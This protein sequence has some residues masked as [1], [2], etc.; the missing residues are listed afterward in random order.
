M[1]NYYKNSDKERFER[2]RNEKLSIH[3][4]QG[5]QIYI[6]YF[7]GTTLWFFILIPV[8]QF[9]HHLSN[10]LHWNNFF[11]SL[12]LTYST[13]VFTFIISLVIT[14]IYLYKYDEND[15]EIKV[16][17]F[18][19]LI[20][21]ITISVLVI[22]ICPFVV[23]IILISNDYNLFP[24]EMELC[25]MQKIFHIFSLLLYNILLLLFLNIFIYLPKRIRKRVK[26]KDNKKYKYIYWIYFIKSTIL[27]DPKFIIGL[28]VFTFLTVFPCFM[29][30]EGGRI[31]ES[32]VIK[33]IGFF[34]FWFTAFIMT[35]MPLVNSLSELGERYHKYTVHIINDII[36]PTLNDHIIIIGTGNLG[37][38]LIK[39][40]FF[41][42]HREGYGINSVCFPK[43][44]FNERRIKDLRDYHIII[45]HNLD[46]F[47]ISRKMVVID[48]N[49]SHF[50]YIFDDKSEFPIGIL[51]P[52]SRNPQYEGVML[53]GICGDAKNR[54]VLNAAR[55]NRSKILVNTNLDTVLSFELAK[56]AK[57]GNPEKQVLS[58]SNTPAFDSLTVYTY[59]NPVYLIDSQHIEG[60]SLS[61]R[62]I[63]WIIKYLKTISPILRKKG[64][65]IAKLKILTDE[66]II[67]LLP[68]VMIIG[69]GGVITN[70]IRSLIFTLYDIYLSDN[71]TQHGNKKELID[72]ILIHNLSV[73]TNDSHI[74][75]EISGEVNSYFNKYYEIK[76]YSWKFYPIR[77]NHTNIYRGNL[78]ESDLY[79]I[80]VYILNTSNFE[81][82]IAALDKERPDL[83]VLINEN[84]YESVAMYNRT[85]DS[86]MLINNGINKEKN[87]NNKQFQPQIITYSNKDDK[88][89]IDDQINKHFVNN[90]N[91][92]E[93]IGF[94]SHL[95]RELKLTR[96]FVTAN[97]FASM[98]RSLIDPDPEGEITITLPEKPG[99][100]A[101]TLIRLSGME[102]DEI[103]NSVEVPSFIYSY[104]FEDRR[105]KNTFVFTGTA[106]L[107]RYSD[108]N[109]KIL[110]FLNCSDKP[111]NHIERKNLSDRDLIKQMLKE[112][113]ISEINNENEFNSYLNPE[114]LRDCSISTMI[115]HKDKYYDFLYKEEKRRFFGFKTN[116]VKTKIESEIKTLDYTKKI[117][118]LAHFKIWGEGIYPG[119]LAESLTNI[120]LGKVKS[121]R[122]FNKNIKYLPN[123]NFCVDYTYQTTKREKIGQENLYI[124]LWDEKKFR[125][126]NKIDISSDEYGRN[127]SH[128]KK[129]F[130][131]GII[132]AVLIKKGG[133][134]T[135]NENKIV[136]DRDSNWFAY[137]IKL[138]KHLQNFYKINN[139]IS[140]NLFL[141]EKNYVEGILLEKYSNELWTNEKTE[142]LEINNY[143]Q[144]DPESKKIMNSENGTK[145]DFQIIKKVLSKDDIQDR[146]SIT[147]DLRTGEKIYALNNAFYTKFENLTQRYELAIIRSDITNNAK[148]NKNKFVVET[149]QNM[150]FSIDDL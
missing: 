1:E 10:G 59:D 119:T 17:I 23:W 97:Q 141:L 114:V 2:I 147:Q 83:I 38:L 55:I 82:Y 71:N 101:K 50:K 146:Y 109:S 111:N 108:E 42:I 122:Y 52:G 58:I 6:S 126:Y 9:F 28:L 79:E 46:I 77:Y 87:N 131:N 5:K 48:K 74:K 21:K 90:L 116:N 34:S 130:D 30:E 96:D 54:Y 57:K 139:G 142:V 120:I 53:I 73:M 16:D 56:L 41:D 12:G 103:D 22:L 4:R 69:Q 39:N 51:P 80:P 3:N 15:I 127:V 95:V 31:L 75:S 132:R 27:Y 110:C 140:Y 137:A 67:D 78:S 148:F 49:N 89:L 19:S 45:D 125:K 43:N 37:G 113:D 136:L 145:P 98:I 105:Y 118:D 61:Q 121:E 144:I 106:K 91:R 24:S 35:A 40:C 102:I 25:K 76:K 20:F 128:R 60:I 112:L 70:T 86:V 33:L 107:S 84:K 63:L 11:V 8:I 129:C 13:F 81:H 29:E 100:L 135:I 123:I 36:L 32:E 62:I 143:L 93:K 149:F 68:K 65:D 14:T 66:T 134:F 7:L 133:V 26:Q 64:S 72:K 44:K 92:R 104:S 18:R 94:P 150:L 117:P 88:F 138:T 99:S 115:N 47:I 85:A 124:R